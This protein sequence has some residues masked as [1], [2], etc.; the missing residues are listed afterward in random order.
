MH[1][2]GERFLARRHLPQQYK[3]DRLEAIVNWFEEV[4]A[5]VP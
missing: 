4:K 1:P 3:G 2:D 5:K